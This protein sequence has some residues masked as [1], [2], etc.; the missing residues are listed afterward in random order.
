MEKIIL[1]KT[2]RKAVAVN[3]HTILLYGKP[4]VGKTSITAQLPNSLL[5]EL[6][7]GGADFVDANVIQAN[8]PNEFEAICNQII[9]D[10]CPYDY[11]IFDSSTRL[12][13]WS[14]IVGTFNY[15]DKNQGKNFNRDLKGQKLHPKDPKF[16]TVHSFRE[17]YMHSRQQMNDWF[18]LMSKCAKHVVILA[19]IKDKFVESK[20]G[21]T[22]EASDINLTGKVKSNYCIRVDSVGHLHR[23]GDKAFINFNTEFSSICG[24]RAKHLKGD[25]LISERQEDD[26]IKTYW[27]N[28]YIKE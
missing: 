13:E 14:E 4:K 16:E 26:S 1:P 7:A 27:E 3:P 2:P 22:V 19:H 11:V 18:N 9:A 25:I 17:G 20:A 6:E 5:V 21:D 28:I 15:M 24:G 10:G 12:D 23:E 8:N